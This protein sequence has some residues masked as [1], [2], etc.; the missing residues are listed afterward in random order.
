V[1][2]KGGKMKKQIS[3]ETFKSSNL[4]P[5]FKKELERFWSFNF[6]NNK[7]NEEN[8]YEFYK[9]LKSYELNCHRWESHYYGIYDIEKR[10]KLNHLMP[11]IKEFMENFER[12]TIRKDY[13]E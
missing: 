2:Y 9:A 6:D 3:D 4:F 13:P 11:K 8:I 10:L 7:N 5:E 1:F 12:V